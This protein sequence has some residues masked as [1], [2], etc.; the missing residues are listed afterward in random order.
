LSRVFEY[1]FFEQ[2]DVLFRDP[3]DSVVFRYVFGRID[4]FF[5]DDF[6]LARPGAE[7]KYG[8]DG[9]VHSEAEEGRPGMS[10][11]GQVEEVDEYAGFAGV[12]VG[13]KDGNAAVLKARDYAFHAVACADDFI[14]F[15]A[16]DV[17]NEA[18]DEGVVDG[19]C[20]DAERDAFD[21]EE[22]AHELPVADVA[23]DADVG[24]GGAAGF[25]EV[26]VTLNGLDEREN[27][28]LVHGAKAGEFAESEGG[29]DVALADD[30]F[31]A[32]G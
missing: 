12:L 25:E 6:V 4:R 28:G 3:S 16:A 30:V 23:G 19:L 2:A 24:F 9:Q 11:C 1:D 29:V 15:G 10:G 8:Q 14:A 5:E 22:S 32:G 17:V 21:G 7:I 27:L 18:V 13:E 26:F 31:D 20:N